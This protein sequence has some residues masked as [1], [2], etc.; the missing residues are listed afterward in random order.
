MEYNETK[1]EK[2]MGLDPMIVLNG[3]G[4]GI[5]TP[6]TGATSV[7]IGQTCFLR[8]NRDGRYWSFKD[9]RKTWWLAWDDIP[10]IKEVMK[11]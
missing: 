7:L 11:K 8:A 10:L 4:Q 6:E 3:L 9:Y 2:H 1:L 5:W